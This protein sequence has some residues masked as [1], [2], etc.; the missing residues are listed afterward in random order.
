MCLRGEKAFLSER[1]VF[2][3]CVSA[4]A[5]VSPCF[6]MSVFTCLSQNRFLCTCLSS[7][8]PPHPSICHFQNVKA[9]QRAL[10][11]LLSSS[12]LRINRLQPALCFHSELHST[13]PS[14]GYMN[15]VEPPGSALRPATALWCEVCC[16]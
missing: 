13:V 10:V 4:L 1:F 6:H 14:S 3:L 5:K 9:S 2:K 7:S 8:L 15:R 12:G 16:H 11:F